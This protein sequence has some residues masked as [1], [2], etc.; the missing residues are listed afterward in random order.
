MFVEL[1]LSLVKGGGRAAQFAPENL[2]NGA[3]AIAIR[4]HFSRSVAYTR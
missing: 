4:R 1:V 3:N 2:Y